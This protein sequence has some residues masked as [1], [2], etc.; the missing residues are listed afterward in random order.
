MTAPLYGRERELALIDE[1]LDGLP[2]RGAA[3]VL[4]GE[5]G[6]GKTALATAAERRAAA[7]GMTVLSTGGVQS[8]T[9]LPYAGLHQ[10]LWPVLADV[11]ALPGPQRNALHAALGVSD[12]RQ[13]DPYLT[14]LAVL[15]LLGDTAERTPVLLVAEDVHWLDRPTCAVLAFVARRLESDA[16]AL[17]VTTRG[18]PPRSIREAGLPTRRL[19]GLDATAADA[20]LRAHAPELT[21]RVRNALLGQAAGNPLA[22]VELPAEAGAD[23]GEL[24]LPSWLPLTTRLERTFTDRVSELPAP[25]RAAL[26]V[27]ALDDQPNVGDALG[28]AS[29]LVGAPVG[30]D[31][32]AVAAAA[33]LIDVEDGVLRF[34]HPLVRS[35]IQQAAPI[36]T[37]QAAH[38]ALAAVLADSAPDRALWQR[39]AATR[40][41][42]EG[43][44]G[45]LERFAA[46]ARR[47][48]S[49]VTAVQTLERAA[50]LTP[51]SGARGRRLLSGA[52]LALEIGRVDLVGRLLDAADPLQLPAPDAERRSWLREMA[53]HDPLDDERL[54]ALL[55]RAERLGPAVD[56][57]QAAPA[58]LTV[59]FR[60]WWGNPSP[61]LR[62]RIVQTSE[63]L[64]GPDVLAGTVVLALVDPIGHGRVVVERL[65]TVDVDRTPPELLRLAAVAACIVGAFDRC[66]AFASTAVSG[67]RA[68]GRYGTL[69][70][71][72]V[73]QAWAG[74][75][76]GDWTGSLP[77][78]EEARRIA[79]ETEQPLWELSATAAASALTG[80][81]GDAA[82]AEELA[83]AAE[84]LLPPRGVDGMRSLIAFARGLTEETAGRSAEA[85]AQLRRVADPRDGGYSAF[86]E[87]WV[88]ADLAQAASGAGADEAIAEIVDR[89]E[90]DD[91][92]WLVAATAYARLLAQ[93]ADADADAAAVAARVEAV[94]RATD[95]LPL[96]RARAQLAHGGWLRRRGL[97]TEARAALRTARD[98]FDALGATAS[99]DAARAEL[100]AAGEA[101]RGQVADPRAVLTAQ[102]LQIAELVAQGRTNR[103][104]GQAL[105]LSHRT[106][107]SHLYRIFPKLGVVS[108]AELRKALTVEAS[109]A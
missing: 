99:G 102:E 18:E 91:S 32:L 39:V 62:R 21:A 46:A 74:V 89:I 45:E 65:A 27:A 4:A 37:R 10:L 19:D 9:L 97:S 25:A 72:L 73:A 30:L 55:E 8:E 83:Q 96:V 109:G 79:R 84:R 11:E 47:R 43:L 13:A 29:A 3:L 82:T 6:I 98:T 70:P 81:R 23:T 41:A 100:R 78:A 80:L 1:I 101:S 26:L 64:L 42:D 38:L 95:G 52:E 71:A 61:Q 67:L 88:L 92:P 86:V 17:I 54:T 57:A 22:L 85:L 76:L 90:G 63:S 58:L 106:V 75:F 87:R 66:V 28:A 35:A 104:I 5:P 59:A 93:T 14:A 56:V 107:G 105:Y 94:L 36:G 69:A 77:L 33:G 20:L 34:R 51:D 50:G 16:V 2:D 108:R 49:L 40:D 44:A 60:C 7:R 24:L 68:R 31:A 12:E 48:G 103:E 15:G 53:D